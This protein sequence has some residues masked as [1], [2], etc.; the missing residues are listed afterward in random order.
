MTA[1]TRATGGLLGTKSAQRRAVTTSAAYT[2][3]LLMT[4]SS[5]ETGLRA[6]TSSP[7]GPMGAQSMKS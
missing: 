3:A 4:A 5:P 2:K 1:G 7:S 6:P